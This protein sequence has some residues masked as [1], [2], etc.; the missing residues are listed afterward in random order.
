MITAGVVEARVQIS[1]R[2]LAF[3]FDGDYSRTS[4]PCSAG[5]IEYA[6]YAKYCGGL[7]ECPEGIVSLL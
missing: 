1:R 4:T 3:R 5:N 7:S 2:P 6:V